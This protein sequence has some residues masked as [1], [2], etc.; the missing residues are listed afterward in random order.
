M[1]L[2]RI[3]GSVDLAIVHIYK[4]AQSFSIDLTKILEPVIQVQ[5]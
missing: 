4:R 1:Q 3:K 2:S 5:L